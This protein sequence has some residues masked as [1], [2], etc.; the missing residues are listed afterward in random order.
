MN[1]RKQILLKQKHGKSLEDKLSIGKKLPS[2]KK[3]RK[4]AEKINQT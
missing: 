4:K 3:N 2:G 1:G